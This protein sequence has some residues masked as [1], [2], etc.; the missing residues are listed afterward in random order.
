[1]LM[2]APVTFPQLAQSSYFGNQTARVQT[3]KILFP[4][5]CTVYI[6]SNNF[7]GLAGRN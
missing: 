6:M 4:N 1:M 2:F 7:C 5:W 3:W